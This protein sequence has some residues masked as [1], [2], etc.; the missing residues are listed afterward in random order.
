MERGSEILEWFHWP[1]FSPEIPGFSYCGN[2]LGN[3]T[4]TFE[5]IGEERSMYSSKI[6]VIL[7]MMSFQLKRGKT[8]SVVT[9]TLGTIH[10]LPF[11]F[12]LFTLLTLK[13][14]K[15]ESV[16]R[17]PMGEGMG[18]V[19]F[20]KNSL[21]RKE[22]QNQKQNI[23]VSYRQSPPLRHHNSTLT[24]CSTFYFVFKLHFKK[25][26]HFFLHNIS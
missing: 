13:K 20:N 18:H 19:S 24:L 3:A 12:F 2:Y 1:L 7:G 8:L 22:K 23:H 10:S 14:S 5:G 11:F 25:K 4:V 9:V 16:T 26:G 21:K 17:E 6:F 15:R